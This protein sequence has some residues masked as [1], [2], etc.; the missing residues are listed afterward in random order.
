VQTSAGLAMIEKN[1]EYIRRHGGDALD[2]Q[3]V[4]TM[5]HGH[6][7]PAF[8]DFTVKILV[9]FHLWHFYDF[10]RTQDMKAEDP[11]QASKFSVEAFDDMGDVS[12]GI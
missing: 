11:S 2:E 10:R 7:L 8:F 1:E 4:K 3:V 6:L 12:I 9:R 5:I